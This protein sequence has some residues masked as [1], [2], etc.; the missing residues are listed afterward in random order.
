MSSPFSWF[1]RKQKVLL[2]VFGVLI[3]I[4]FTVGGIISSSLQ[5][6]M[7]SG[8]GTDIVA[9]WKHGKVSENDLRM[10][11]YNHGV[12][13]RFLDRVVEETRVREGWPK[14]P[15]VN[16]DRFGRI[17][18]PGIPRSSQEED[19]VRTMLMAQK[20]A[21]MGMVVTKDAI[22]EF[23]KLLCDDKLRRP[24]F[25]RLLEATDAQYSQTRLFRQLQTELLAQNLESIVWRGLMAMP[26]DRA[27]EYFNRFN[28]Q[29]EAE[30][31]PVKAKDFDD[32]VTGEPKDSQV[33]ALYEEAKN[34][35][36]NPDPDS[37]KPGFKR[38]KTIVFQYLKVDYNKFLEK[39]KTAIP[40][41]E[42]EKYYEEHKD[43][44]KKVALPKTDDEK[45][46]AK[47]SVTPGEHDASEDPEAKTDVGDVSGK[48]EKPSPD[49]TDDASAKEKPKTPPK[50]EPPTETADP[51]K[52]T[53]E[54]PKK[55][56]ASAPDVE[57]VPPKTEPA[58]SGKPVP[59]KDARGVSPG[60]TLFVSFTAEPEPK[61]AQDVAEPKPKAK[62]VTE[63]KPKAKDAPDAKPEAKDAPEAVPG[64]QDT[65]PKKPES[66]D[67]ADVTDGDSETEKP[68]D[69]PGSDAE[70]P[71]AKDEAMPKASPTPTPKEKTDNGDAAA[72][73]KD[74]PA[75][76]GKAAKKEKPV[77]YESLE[78]VED[79]IRGIIA[80]PIAEQKRKEAFDA[81]EQEVERY[82]DARIRWE[83]MVKHGVEATE[84]PPLD[85][86]AL[87]DE[88][89]LTAG[90]TAEL[91][92]IDVV[93]DSDL[94]K[95]YLNQ[96]GQMVTF[97]QIAYAD[98]IPLYKPYRIPAAE[99]K[100]DFLYWKIEEEDWK[101]ED[102]E[103]ESVP[104]LDDVREEVIDAWRRAEALKLARRYAEK[105]AKQAKDGES[106]SVLLDEE[107]AK[108]VVETGKFSWMFGGA[109]PMGMGA[110][111]ISPVVGVESP[112]EDFMKA[113][114]AL[115]EGEVG[116]AVNEPQSIVYAVRFI[117]EPRTEEQR[118][119]EFMERMQTGGM[120]AMYPHMT[121]VQEIMGDWRKDLEK[122]MN[123]KWERPPEIFRPR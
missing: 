98:D 95:A 26:P 51:K 83:S 20:A 28:R 112:G 47:P 36:P 69:V 85:H 81:A 120:F 105:L 60:D 62:D 119:I 7:G 53:S 78:E 2:V 39:E 79:R 25:G 114:F 80:T 106:L 88:L 11:R 61:D 18:D 104:E 21:D 72:A 49:V 67:A 113:V 68:A 55:T 37:A 108:D 101:S 117:S 56:D 5:R 9:R 10:M 92:E 14:A 116:V 71:K 76:D 27:W 4:S 91:N 29:I 44:F 102:G 73:D 19:L 93:T 122:E 118:R 84:P 32:K 89:N 63:A 17:V 3:M 50:T 109:L 23:L 12:A 57:L 65:T 94:G 103:D 30:V 75:K 16:R 115:Q 100:V 74:A 35:Y 13:V 59:P 52:E 87:E 86:E 96:G 54:P 42:V 41:E 15:G 82:F 1:R 111:R 99:Y 40:M 8:G 66:K 77:E 123:L 70:K 6:H 48:E 43:E 46:E 34:D 58:D 33:E 38:R 107:Q 24:D 22:W 121:A 90:E 64:D 97:P 110:P 31:Y 45:P